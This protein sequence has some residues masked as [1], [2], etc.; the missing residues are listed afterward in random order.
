[1]IFFRN[2]HTR[3]LHVGAIRYINKNKEQTW[4]ADDKIVRILEIWILLNSDGDSEKDGCLKS[5]TLF[6][7][8]TEKLP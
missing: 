4:K 6:K 3:I 2:K 5:G 7:T 8:I 1:M